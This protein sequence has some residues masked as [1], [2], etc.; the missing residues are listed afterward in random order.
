MLRT[1]TVTGDDRL[2]ADLQ[3]LNVED[4]RGVGRDDDLAGVVQ[5]RVR[6]KP[7]GRWNDEPAR[8]AAAH[9]DHALFEPV[10]ERAD[11]RGEYQRAS[12]VDRA[13][14]FRAVEEVAR[15]VDGDRA[16]PWRLF[17]DPAAT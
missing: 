4:D 13:V 9:A 5:D 15:V 10:D 17:S 14:E 12:D 8:G 6:P 2:V 7:E 16:A 3:H 1:G 11:A